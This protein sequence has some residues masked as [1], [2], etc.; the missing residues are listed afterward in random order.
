MKRTTALLLTALSLVFLNISPLF[1]KIMEENGPGF[2]L[3][4]PCPIASEHHWPSRWERTN[5]CIYVYIDGRENPYYTIPGKNSALDLLPENVRANFRFRVV[6]YR[7]IIPIEED[8]EYFKADV[9]LSLPLS[10]LPKAEFND[11][12]LTEFY[13]YKN[14]FPD[15]EM[16]TFA[17]M[18]ATELYR[19]TIVS[20]YEYAAS[21]YPEGSFLG[22]RQVNRAEG[23]K[24]LLRTKF[25]D[26]EK[27]T[28]LDGNG[29]F[30]DV[31]ENEWYRKYVVK[32]A[33]KRII[34]GYPDGTFRPER[35]INK[36]EF[37]KMMTIAFDLPKNLPHTFVDIE[38]GAWYE[39]YVGIVERYNLFPGR[40]VVNPPSRS[41]LHPGLPMTRNEVAVALYQY[42]RLR[43]DPCCR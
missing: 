36:V 25:G 39:K 20:G 38:P 11:P 26:V 18:A 37:L 6:P 22:D 32:A 4:K 35:S 31:L 30:P 43:D 8:N 41:A 10:P 19:R 5:Y 13:K 2:V 16:N 24:F 17:G 23:A 34:K 7:G 3:H 40:I 15:T 33:Q 28:A 1:A 27:E 21:K 9:F 12:V 29:G 14:P 42:L